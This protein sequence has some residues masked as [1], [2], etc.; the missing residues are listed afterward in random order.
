M[1]PRIFDAFDQRER[2]VM[3]YMAGCAMKYGMPCSCGPSC[4]CKN[5]PVHS[6]NGGTDGS[7]VMGMSASIEAQAI[8]AHALDGGESLGVLEPDPLTDDVIHVDQKMDF[9]GMEPPS[10]VQHN[11]QNNLHHAPLGGISMIPESN[12]MPQ[13]AAAPAAGMYNSRRSQRNPSIISY[14]GLRNMSINSETTFGRAM[15]GLSALSIDWEN[16]EDFDLEVDH[17]AHINNSPMGARR[18]SVRRSFA[19]ASPAGGSTGESESQVSFKV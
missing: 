1:N 18:A 12:V 15:S 14:G 19:A 3:D 8:A 2:Q 9:F 16:L 4:R 6:N 17:S 5:C 11:L 7:Q 13:D 10:A